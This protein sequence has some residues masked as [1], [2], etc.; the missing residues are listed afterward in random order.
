MIRHWFWVKMILLCDEESVE[1][2]KRWNKMSW[3][4]R[5]SITILSITTCYFRERPGQYFLL[6][7][8]IIFLWRGLILSLSL[9]NCEHGK[10]N[11]QISMVTRVDG[12]DSQTGTYCSILRLWKVLDCELGPGCKSMSVSKDLSCTSDQSNAI[13]R[14]DKEKHKLTFI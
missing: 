13:H 11:L 9:K 10:T 3:Q 12:S 7:I 14:P 1:W 2:Y 8:K 4:G 5:W 6:D